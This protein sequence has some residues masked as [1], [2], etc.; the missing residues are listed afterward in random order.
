VQPHLGGSMSVFPDEPGP[1][2]V[3]VTI[4][5]P[6]PEQRRSPW[7]FV[8]LGVALVVLVVGGV[9]F[10]VKQAATHSKPST[11]S[12]GAGFLA[13][14]EAKTAQIND[15]RVSITMNMS[16]GGKHVVQR[17]TGELSQKPLL[18][19]LRADV[20]GFGT[21]DERVVGHTLYIRMPATAAGSKHWVSYTVAGDAASG[22]VGQTD[23]LANLKALSGASGKVQRIG[24]QTIDGTKTTHYKSTLDIRAVLGKLPKDFSQLFEGD[25]SVLGS[26]GDIPVDVYIADDG[27]VRRMTERIDM[28]GMSMAVVLDLTPLGHRADVSAP[29]AGDVTNVNNITDL[30]SQLGESGLG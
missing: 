2:P 24:T 22:L 17:M 14:A 18:M 11:V 8:I 4:L 25:S 7:R 6:E 29:P 10:G 20:P 1:G 5:A 30:F 26:L 12:I 28:S 23:P 19:S 13:A 16:M 27:T 21:L 9:A 3:D 15:F